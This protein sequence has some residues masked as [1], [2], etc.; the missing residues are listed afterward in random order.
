MQVLSSKTLEQ[1]AKPQASML[2]MLAFVAC[3]LAGCGSDFGATASG[4]VSLDGQPVTPGQVTFALKDANTVPAI[5]QLNNAGRYELV[6][7]KK[8][9]LK[10]GKYRVAVQAF[11]PPDLAEGTRTF[12]PSKPLSLIH[13][14]EPT[15]PY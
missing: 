15:R 11:Q 1:P 4:V 3:C 2:L 10:P 14:S 7:Q 8:V 13:I 5:S 12:E 9:G 6:T